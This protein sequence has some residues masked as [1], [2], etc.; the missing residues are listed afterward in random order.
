MASESNAPNENLRIKE[1]ID[2]DELDLVCCRTLIVSKGCP[3]M[4]PQTPET[5]PASASITA[6]REFDACAWTTR[7]GWQPGEVASSPFGLRSIVIPVFK[8]HIND[9]TIISLQR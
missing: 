6:V 7:A 2:E 8:M 4:T 9:L 5:L 3:T 1:I